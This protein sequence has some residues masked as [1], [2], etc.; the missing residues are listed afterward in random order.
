[1]KGIC[2]VHCRLRGIHMF[3]AISMQRAKQLAVRLLPM[4]ACLFTGVVIL[5]LSMAASAQAARV[6]YEY[7]V[8]TATGGYDPEKNRTLINK[9]YIVAFGPDDFESEA[10]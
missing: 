3:L 1:M 10:K 8:A 2:R 9:F 6:W 4:D 7:G 5:G